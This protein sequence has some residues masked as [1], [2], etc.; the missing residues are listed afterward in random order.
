MYII[1]IHKYYMAH[2]PQRLIAQTEQLTR[3]CRVD[4]LPCPPCPPNQF[5]LCL[6]YQRLVEIERALRHKR[7]YVLPPKTTP[8]LTEKIYDTA[9]RIHWCVCG[10][11][12]ATY[13]S[14]LHGAEKCLQLLIAALSA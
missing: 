2:L 10:R 7:F 14:Y 1:V 13:T 12:P 3:L 6:V 5:H 8:L 11:P 4:G 9:A